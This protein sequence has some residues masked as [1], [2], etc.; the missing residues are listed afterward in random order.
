[1]FVVYTGSLPRV[2]VPQV[3]GM[4]I[5]RGVPVEVPDE[6]GAA[7]L[8]QR[9]WQPVNEPETEASE[10]EAMTV[11]ELKEA[12]DGLGLHVPSGTRKADLVLMVSAEQER[13]AASE[14]PADESE[15]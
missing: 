15:E 7:L 11:D 6:L 5:E 2:A 8:E 4:V 9:A 3:R 12:A 13:R 10:L 14:P 1:M